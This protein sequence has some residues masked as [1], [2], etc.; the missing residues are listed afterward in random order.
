MLLISTY[1]FKVISAVTPQ[2]QD[3]TA[4]ASQIQIKKHVIISITNPQRPTHNRNR[5]R[6][7]GRTGI[8]MLHVIISTPEAER[9]LQLR[10]YQ[11][12]QMGSKWLRAQSALPACIRAKMHAVPRDEVCSSCNIIWRA[13]RVF[14]YYA[15]WSCGVASLSRS[16]GMSRPDFV[17]QSTIVGMSLIKAS[18]NAW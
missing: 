17:R 2:C 15:T 10:L 18:S 12:K 8:H 11:S 1:K 3:T 9:A 4:F 16:T 13:V 14:F 6:Q 5:A 7:L